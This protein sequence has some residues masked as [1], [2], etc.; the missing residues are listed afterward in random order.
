[1]T[2]HLRTHLGL[3]FKGFHH[4]AYWE[5]GPAEAERTVVCVHGLTRQGRDFD[6]LA[7]ALVRRGCRVVCPDLAGRGMS[8]WL[9]DGSGYTLVQYCADMN[10]LVARLDVDQV[11]WVGN[12]L[13]GLIGMILAG[14]RQHPIR[15][16]VIND[17]GPFIPGAALRR[18]GG[19]LNGPPPHFD[20]LA[21]A[22]AHFRDILAPYGVLSDEQWRH[23]TEHSIRRHA[24]GG[25]ILRCDPA[26]G[27]AY[28]PW[29]VGSITMW[30]QW[31]RVSCPTL[32]LR[33]ALS[34]MLLA[35]TAE[36][37][38]RRGPKARLIEFPAIGHVPTL[39]TQDQIGPV[40]EFLTGGGSV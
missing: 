21:G 24:E 6:V 7:R 8:D 9:P 4:L 28:R 14:Q 27:E 31:D 22:E 20:D 1:M 11:D 40:I 13:G 29:R 36:E 10:A 38:T 32:L 16:L 19:Y 5:W 25:Y 23:L 3:S 34:D 30:E 15:R 33:G 18:I 2:P 26:I 17:I 12:S 35:A 39:M 37:M